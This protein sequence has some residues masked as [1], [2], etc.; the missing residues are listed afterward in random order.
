MS[1]EGVRKVI[2]KMIS[3]P[4]FAKAVH[5]NAATAIAGSGYALDTREVAA[6]SKIK[7]GDL[8]LQIKPGGPGNAGFSIETFTSVKTV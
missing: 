1:Q 5:A 8:S 3:E 4:N 7:P 6:I 2:G